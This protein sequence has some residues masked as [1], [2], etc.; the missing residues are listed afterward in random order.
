MIASQSMM[1]SRRAAVGVN[2]AEER[3]SATRDVSARESEVRDAEE[4]QPPC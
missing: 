1:R 4:T 2:I 3:G